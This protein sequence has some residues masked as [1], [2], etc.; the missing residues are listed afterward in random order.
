MAYK[1]WKVVDFEYQAAVDTYLAAYYRNSNPQL[2]SAYQNAVRTDNQWIAEYCRQY[3]GLTRRLNNAIDQM[4]NEQF[5]NF[6]AKYSS[7][8]RYWL[9]DN[10]AD[11]RA[12]AKE[13]EYLNK[14]NNSG[15]RINLQGDTRW[16][17]PKP[18]R[19]A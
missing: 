2:S 18:D 14:W 6:N 19:H 8:V 9:M 5:A 17:V 13:P 7:D 3:I 10:V 16:D 4:Q 11:I 15:P 12:H 1:A